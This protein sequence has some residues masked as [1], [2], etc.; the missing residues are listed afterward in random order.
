MERVGR[1]YNAGRAAGGILI[2][3]AG[4]YSRALFAHQCGKTGKIQCVLVVHVPERALAGLIQL[5]PN[6]A[7]VDAV[8]HGEVLAGDAASDE[9]HAA[10]FRRCG[11]FAGDGSRRLRAAVR[12]AG[13]AEAVCIYERKAG[14]IF[15][16]RYCA[17]GA[18]IAEIGAHGAVIVIGQHHIAAAR[19]LDAVAGVKR[20]RRVAAGRYH[21]TSGGRFLRG[22][23]RDEQ[24][25]GKVHALI[26]KP[27][28]TALLHTEASGERGLQREKADKKHKHGG[29]K[30]GPA[31][32]E[33]LL[34]HVSSSQTLVWRAAQPAKN[35][36]PGR[37]LL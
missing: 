12:V 11:I 15:H 16:G 28:H 8:I 19:Q 30:H 25:A 24:R 34:F 9:Q 20:V 4:L 1:I 6:G 21:D 13:G 31:F 2:P 32:A 27:V 3:V 18:V 35:D 14:E 17:R 10:V 33:Y 29:Q 36:S 37:F 22:I 7:Y 5:A 23:F 26:S